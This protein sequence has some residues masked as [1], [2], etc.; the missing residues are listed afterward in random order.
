MEPHSDTQR[1][2]L[3]PS[4]SRRPAILTFLILLVAVLFPG[5]LRL[6]TDNSPAVFFVED[7]ERV[8]SYE[9]HR[10]IFGSDVTLRLVF[11][12]SGLW[13]TRHLRWM[14]DLEEELKEISGVLQV[15]G[16]QS[17]YRRF[18][19]PPQDLDAFRARAVANTLDRG[20][21]W[22]S[23]DGGIVTL[24]VQIEALSSRENTL[25]LEKVDTL[26]AT[27]PEGVI[28]RVVG[29]PVLNH[30]LDQ[31]SREVEHVFFPL[32]ILLTVLLLRW[33][34]GSFRRIWAPLLFVGLCQ[35]MVLSLMGYADVRLNMVLAVLPP[36]VF[37][38]SLATAVHL[39]LHLRR[40]PVSAGSTV[41][42]EYEE[43][44]ESRTFRI[45]TRLA[46]VFHEK[47]WAVL[48]TGVTTVAGFASLTLSPLSP[49]RALGLWSAI[50]LAAATAAV[51]LFLPTLM[52]VFGFG[53]ATASSWEGRWA[54]RGEALGRRARI[55]RKPILAAAGFACI[56]AMLGLPRLHTVSNALEYL[57]PDHP[58]RAGIER[59]EDHG[60][61][62][63][64]I[65]LLVTMPPPGPGG[66]PPAF[67]SAIEVDRLA[68]LGTE[69]EQIPGVFGV[70][71]IGSVLR[72]AL[73]HVPTTPTNAHFRQQMALES[74]HGDVEGR[75]VLDALLTEDRLSA[76]ATIFVETTDI[77]TLSHISTKILAATRNHF[78]EASAHTTGQYPLL[79]EAQEHLLSTLFSS[80]GLTLLV[81]AVILRFVLPSFR[82]AL[83]ALVPNIWPVLGTF[84]IMGWLGVP[85]DIASVMMASVVLGL[86]VDDSIHTLG[87]FRRLAPKLGS[88]AAVE[89][90][91]FA[92]AP[93]YVLTSLILMSGFGVC[94]LSSFAPIA[95]FGTMS[96][97]AIALALIGDLFLL[98]ALLSLTPKDVARRLSPRPT[99]DGNRS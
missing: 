85:L 53:S 84:G 8:E 14:S 81:V 21:G 38:V 64:G 47:R 96:A 58:L 22:I 90:T 68:D 29:L 25:L 26:I 73:L 16:L 7:S 1:A 55:H 36:L 69:L 71:S 93:A 77:D 60:I 15:S 72:D 70:V 28:C 66:A 37:A 3:T 86:A 31:S 63:A 46:T 41:E 79:L 49:V 91:L 61:G 10:E 92:T 5:L 20:A 40:A 33:V 98:P 50:G 62:V 42:T 67:T 65:E 11:E 51:F 39:V 78:P 9:R 30:E 97:V 88:G 12:G 4:A 48:W 34:L 59:L 94:A 27:P 18:G 44:D 52:A 24:L 57:A 23:A 13:S 95:R 35:I 75:A 82:L 83:L 76:H 80:L 43:D 74:L 17:H 99:D 89:K 45:E 19:W 56:V 32:L 6:E 54:R 2:K 87:H